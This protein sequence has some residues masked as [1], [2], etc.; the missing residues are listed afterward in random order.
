MKKERLF[1]VSYNFQ[2]RNG[3]HGFGSIWLNLVGKKVNSKTLVDWAEFIRE[4]NDMKDVII[5]F[6]KELEE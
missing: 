1:Y 3:G 6:Y 2:N 4:K 5:M